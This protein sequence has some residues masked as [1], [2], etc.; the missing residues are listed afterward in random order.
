MIKYQGCWTAL[1]TPFTD[2]YEIDWNGF[3]SNIAFQIAEGVS[4]ILP[5]GTTGESPTVSH[6]EHS[7]VI[8]KA[9]EFS[10]KKCN[11]FGG[12][13]SNSTDEALM[14]T[15]KAFKAGV[16]AVLL[17]DAY[18]NKPSSL[19]LRKEYYGT[20]AEKFSDLNILPYVIP[21][22]SGTALSPEDLAILH[23]EYNNIF[24]VKEATGDLER[25]RKTRALLGDYFSIFSGDDF[26]TFDM[27]TDPKIKAC[28]VISVISNVVP[29]SVQKLTRHLL[30][31]RIDKARELNEA[32]KPLFSLVGVKTKDKVNLPDGK[33]AE[34]EYK[35]PNPVPVKT[36]MNGL[37]M[38]AGICRKPLGRLSRSGVEIVRNALK[39]VWRN[40]PEIL[41]PI[42][43]HYHVS[44]EERLS[45]DEYWN[46]LA[47]RNI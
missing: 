25:M 46:K 31:G 43:G 37:G 20:I 18:Y 10:G 34:I 17:V 8:R 3:R 44:V 47:Y 16:D 28:G 1:V 14:E 26:I 30:E 24:G 39:D 42:E 40:N 13:G 35:F 11:V 21:G 5:M 2:D 32:L 7:A 36:I 12:T 19:E 27:M 41:K 23:N 22:R 38:N 33:T 4:G 29:G 9:I 15:E 6:D 45:K